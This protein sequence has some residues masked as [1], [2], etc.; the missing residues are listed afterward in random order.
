M[1]QNEDTGAEKM[2]T[3]SPNG[4]L[5]QTPVRIVGNEGNQD[6]RECL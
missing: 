6:N 1:T 4:Q 2:G 5:H 3:V